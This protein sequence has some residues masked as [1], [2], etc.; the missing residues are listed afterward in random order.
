MIDNYNAANPFR[1]SNAYY[2]LPSEDEWYKAAYYDPNAN[3]GAGG[4]WNYA[5][6]SDSAPTAVASGTTSGTAVYDQSAATG[7][8]ASDGVVRWLVR[9]CMDRNLISNRQFLFSATGLEECG[10]SQLADRQTA[11]RGLGCAHEFGIGD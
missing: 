4:Y 8:M 2:F 5:T 1:N 9:L 10:R 3:G 6:G 11:E 7:P